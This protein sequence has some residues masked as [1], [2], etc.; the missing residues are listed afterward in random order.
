MKID[1]PYTKELLIL[2]DIFNKNNS[3]N[4]RIVGGAIRNYLM[5]KKIND[6]DLSTKLTPDESIELLKNNKIKVVPTGI[7]FG[8]I[9]AIVKGKSFEITTTRKDIKT[10]GRHAIVEFTKNFEVDAKRRDFTFNALYLDFNGNLYDYFD[11]ITDLKKGIVR[12]IGNAEDRIKED[13]LR[14]LRFFRFYCYYAS[15]LDTEGLEYS[16]K[17]KEKLRGLSGER[18]KSEMFKILVADY[19]IKTLQIMKQ[20][21]ILQIITG[22]NS[23]DFNNLEFLFSIKKFINYE[24][25]AE[26]VL[27]LLLK[28][29][30]ELNILKEKWKL[31]KKENSE[32]FRIIEHSNN[33]I[34]T[35]KEIAKFLF[36]GYTKEIIASFIIV[37]AII[38]RNTIENNIVDTINKSIEYLKL[39]EIPIFPITGLVLEEFEFTNKKQF[40]KLLEEGKRIFAESNY[41]LSKEKLIQHLKNMTI[42][43]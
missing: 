30:D 4:L 14:I 39:K 18:I 23:F 24:I 25:N 37:N 22:L 26:L 29:L 35:E 1:F 10:D 36:S 13:Y 7:K 27:S 42:L 43:E 38:N 19:P 33:E 9:M 5:N 16:T 40:G 17:H 28:N 31:S 21:G 15:V 32:I 6:F 2:N 12:F 8:T 3:D 20:N 41:S 34:Y 11:G